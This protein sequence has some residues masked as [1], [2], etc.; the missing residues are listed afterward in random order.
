MS[1]PKAIQSR[2]L[3]ANK[4][5]PLSDAQLKSFLSSEGQGTNL[6][7]SHRLGHVY[8]EHWCWAQASK[9]D[10]NRNGCL[11]P[12]HSATGDGYDQASRDTC[13]ADPEME[14]EHGAQC[15]K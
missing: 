4:G 6:T 7:V 12:A 9:A 15:I 5:E 2:L 14:C 8:F 1:L 3:A 13:Q 10:G 11:N